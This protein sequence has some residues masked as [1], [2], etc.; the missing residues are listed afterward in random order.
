MYYPLH[1]L[2]VLCFIACE[3]G[4]Y[5]STINNLV[6]INVLAGENFKAPF[7][8]CYFKFLYT[9]RECSKT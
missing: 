5:H 9:L 4:Y 3:Q 7:N 1:C 8:I 6:K 2:K